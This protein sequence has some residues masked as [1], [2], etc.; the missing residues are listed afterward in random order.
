MTIMRLYS[1]RLC[2]L[3]DAI[4]R[5]PLCSYLFDFLYE[6]K[7]KIVNYVANILI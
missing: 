1:L 4:A 3:P 6:K 5:R 7:I 2:L